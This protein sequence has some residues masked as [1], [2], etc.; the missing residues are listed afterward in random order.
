[1]K[2]SSP[3]KRPNILFI[4]SD[5]HAVQAISALNPEGSQLNYTP[6]MDRIA[7]EGAVFSNSFCANSICTPSRASILTGKHSYQNGVLTLRSAL[8]HDQQTFAGLLHQSG[9]STALVGKWHLIN[10]P[11]E[12]DFDF[13]EVLPGQGSYYNPEYITPQGTIQREGYSADI[14]TDSILNWLENGRDPAKPFLA[15]LQFKAPHRPWMPPPRHYHLY[16]GHRFPEPPTYHDDYAN[17]C[18]VLKT[19]EMEITRHMRW[20]TDLKVRDPGPNTHR[21][22]MAPTSNGEHEYN[23]MTPEQLAAWN[24]AYA[25]REAYVRDRELSDEE[26]ESFAYQAYVTDYLR[27]IAAVDDNVGRALD[28][29][30]EKGLAE[31]TIVVYCSDQGFYLGEHRWYDK[32][33]IFEESMRMPL[34]IRWPGRIKEGIRHS[35]LVQNIDYAPS[36]LE[37]CGVDVPEDMQGVSLLRLLDDGAERIHDDLY[38][39][40]Y[41]HGGHGVPAHDGLRTLRYKLIHFYTENEFNLFDLEQDPMEMRSLHEDPAY[42]DILADMKQRYQQARSRYGV[43]DEYGPGGKFDS[44]IA[45][46]L[47]DDD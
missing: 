10:P 35:A 11:K 2:N 28:Y 21:L 4:L 31:N 38:Y 20:N 30:D 15:C 43:P 5:D 37:A 12:G 8:S 34:M 42:A 36:L 17:R 7:Q 44:R 6:N 3:A 18:E 29:L 26:F 32:R 24:Q 9:Y 45:Q 19:N 13:W 23:R 39:H 1:M 40:Y 27:C 41:E 46:C 16:D 14:T 47:H 22:A 33:W 25:E